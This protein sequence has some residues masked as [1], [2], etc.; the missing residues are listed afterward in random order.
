MAKTLAQR[1]ISGEQVSAGELRSSSESAVIVA[2]QAKDDLGAFT[3]HL[4][5]EEKKVFEKIKDLNLHGTMCP[6]WSCQ[7][8]LDR[9]PM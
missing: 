1:I 6:C 3:D 2:L 8:Q 4:T 9:F 5:S 7:S